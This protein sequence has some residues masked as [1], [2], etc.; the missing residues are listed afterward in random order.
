MSQ[1]NCTVNLRERAATGQTG[2]VESSWWLALGSFYERV[3]GVQRER[4]IIPAHA[5]FA[6]I[7]L[8][9]CAVILGAC[10]VPD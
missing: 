8:Y 1:I 2:Q 10:Q 9:I 4:I 7:L 3:D 6:Q 5:I